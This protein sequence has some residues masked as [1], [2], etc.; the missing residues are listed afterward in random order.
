M[1]KE[2]EKSTIKE[3][4]EILKTEESKMNWIAFSC[5]IIITLLAIIALLLYDIDKNIYNLL[6]FIEDGEYNRVVEIYRE[7][8]TP[9][10]Y[11]PIYG[12]ISTTESESTTTTTTTTTTVSK[13]SSK[14]YVINKS[15]KKIHLKTCSFADRIN[16]ENKYEVQLTQSELQSYLNDGYAFCST[17]GG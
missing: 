7:E 15:S 9:E 11:L 14:S 13:E 6:D 5:V 16:E 4:V 2:Q 10:D 17:C 8:E 1:N 3:T 12:V